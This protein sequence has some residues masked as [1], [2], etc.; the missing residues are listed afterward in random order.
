MCILDHD[1]V[2]AADKFGNIFILRT[3]ELVNEDVDTGS[4]QQML[5]DQGK[6]SGAPNK[7]DLLTHYYLGEVITSLTKCCL[8]PGGVEVM[9]ASTIMGGLYA[10]IPF[11]SK[12]DVKLFQHLEM[13]MRQECPNLC[14]RDH[15]SYRSYFQPVKDTI[16][17]DLCEKYATMSVAKQKELASDVDRTPT[18]MM[19]KLEEIRSVM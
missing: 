12:E 11:T 2:G 17:G 16:D 13:F 5:W 9:I 19:K 10:F 1:T 8:I 14:Q 4:G 3:P 6:L 7:V 15:L 18:E